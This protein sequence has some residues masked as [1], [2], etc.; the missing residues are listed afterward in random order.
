[1]SVGIRPD[2]ILHLCRTKH[3]WLH[4]TLLQALLGNCLLIRTQAEAKAAGLAQ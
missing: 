2:F 1:M 4:G 3:R